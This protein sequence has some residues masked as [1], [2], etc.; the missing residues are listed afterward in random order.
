MKSD[1]R[2]SPNFFRRCER[3]YPNAVGFVR[4]HIPLGW[5]AP[6]EAKPEQPF[7]I[8][9]SSKELEEEVTRILQQVD[10]VAVEEED[11]IEEAIAPEEV[12]SEEM[13][14]LLSVLSAARLMMEAEMVENA[15]NEAEIVAEEVPVK[16]VIVKEEEKETPVKEEVIVK[17]EE[18][19]VKEEKKEVPVKEEVIVKEEEKEAPVKEEEKEE[20]K[21]GVPMKEKE[22][23][24]VKEEEKET[25]VKKEV[26][27]KKEEPS[28][29][30]RQAAATLANLTAEVAALQSQLKAV[31]KEEA[32]RV[33]A[34]LV[35]AIRAR[36]YG[37]VEAKKAREVLEET[38]RV[39]EKFHAGV[40]KL[41]DLY[42][43]SLQEYAEETERTEKEELVAAVQQAEDA[44]REEI[45]RRVQGVMAGVSEERA[46]R[47]AHE[48]KLKEVVRR[49]VEHLHTQDLVLAELEA[50]QES[51]K[52][53][54]RLQEDVALGR[55]LGA[56]VAAL[57]EESGRCE[58]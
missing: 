18:V 37:E 6:E 32:E 15:K 49:Q 56:S 12:N 20:E 57:V 41:R 23:V 5:P 48:E 16:E 42:H 50:N 26:I 9:M 3:E 55:P 8:S 51:Q 44:W 11:A 52:A 53:F 29:A 21:E 35:E 39:L 24:I 27:V 30:E 17:E 34:Q 2:L 43:S 28:S 46:T 31:A 45:E 14:H 13:N 10:P 40:A 19:P 54:I 7:S 22:G 4:H 1:R 33:A 47:V 58:A 36:V 38:N 25:P